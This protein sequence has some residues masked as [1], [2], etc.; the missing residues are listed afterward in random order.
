L[1]AIYDAVGVRIRKLPATP[2]KVRA[3]MRAL[4]ASRGERNE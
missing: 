4:G 3:A 2:D 1:N